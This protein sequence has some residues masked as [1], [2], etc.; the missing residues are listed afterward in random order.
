M[1]L[2]FLRL[3]TDGELHFKF[4]T[5]CIPA[6]GLCTNTIIKVYRINTGVKE[7]I[8]FVLFLEF[9]FSIGNGQ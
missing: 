2:L 8:D 9:I 3:G 7:V 5:S 1:N 4:E 6:C